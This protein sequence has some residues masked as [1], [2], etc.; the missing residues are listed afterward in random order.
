MSATP[1]YTR[2]LQFLEDCKGSDGDAKYEKALS[3]LATVDEKSLIVDWSD[4]YTFD[5]GLAT[6]LLNE[7]RTLLQ[8]F[9][10]AASQ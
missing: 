8:D 7:P 1:E 2:L 9:I 3:R 10:A 4:L 6:S 5:T